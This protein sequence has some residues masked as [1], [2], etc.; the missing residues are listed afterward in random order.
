MVIYCYFKMCY[1]CP[2][3]ETEVIS[4]TSNFSELKQIVTEVKHVRHESFCSEGTKR[5]FCSEG[6]KRPL[7]ITCAMENI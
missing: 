7:P 6:T 2:I 4:E 1:F 5:P 3:V